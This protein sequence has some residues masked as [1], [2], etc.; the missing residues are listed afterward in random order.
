MELICDL[1]TSEAE[2]G[3]WQTPGYHGLNSKAL[4]CPYSVKQKT[5]TKEKCLLLGIVYAVTELHR[6]WPV[7]VVHSFSHTGLLS[8][9]CHSTLAFSIPLNLS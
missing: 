6:P 8:F 2:L 3:G 7:S 9:I 4:S 1:R 5:F